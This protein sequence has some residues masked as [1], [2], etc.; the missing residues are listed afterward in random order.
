[1]TLFRRP[2]KRKFKRA[3]FLPVAGM[4]LSPG[5]SAMVSP[6]DASLYVKL[7]PETKKRRLRGSS[8][9]RR[10]IVPEGCHYCGCG[11]GGGGSTGTLLTGGGGSGGGTMLLPGYTKLPSPPR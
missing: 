2:G 11:N 1:M 9:R 8:R 3:V 6:S 10:Q 7:P 5:R 4:W